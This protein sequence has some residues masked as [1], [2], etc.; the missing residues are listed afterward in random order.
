V[1][2]VKSASGYDDALD[3]VGVHG[4]GGATGC[5]LGGLFNSKAMGAAADGLFYGG[6]F[7]LMGAQLV[8]VG[9]VAAYTGICTWI[10]LKILDAIFG[11]RVTGDEEQEGLDTS[12]HGEKAYHV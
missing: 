4:V 2:F 11:M 8:M 7:S 12:Q 10:I 3:V 1:V 9:A 5:I 6:G